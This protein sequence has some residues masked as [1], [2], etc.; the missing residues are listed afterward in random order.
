MILGPGEGE[1]TSSFGGEDR[2]MEVD[3]AAVTLEAIGAEIGTLDI[4]G[5]RNEPGA[6]RTDSCGRF[7]EVSPAPT[8]DEPAEAS[9]RRQILR[10]SVFGQRVEWTPKFELVAR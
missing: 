7:L 9:T 2:A 6:L 3:F 5:D 8:Q 4:D 10:C 1:I